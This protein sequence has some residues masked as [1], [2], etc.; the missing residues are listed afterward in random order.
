MSRELLWQDKKRPIFGK[1]WSFTTYLLYD[2]RLTVKHGLLNVRTDVMML[3]RILDISM[4]QTFVDKMF[5]VGSIILSSA[6]R[7]SPKLRVAS[8]K[9]PDRVMDILSD[10]VESIRDKK[11]IRPHE[12]I[13]S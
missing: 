12:F 9:D 5:G 8:V 3:Y 6:D 11:G 7:S 2:D 1:P 10:R 4:E 13:N